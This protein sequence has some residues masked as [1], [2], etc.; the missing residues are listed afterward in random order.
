MADTPAHDKP[1]VESR[2][3]YDNLRAVPERLLLYHA[4]GTIRRR[5]GHDARKGRGG[6]GPCE[7]YVTEELAERL[8]VLAGRDGVFVFLCAAEE[9]EYLCWCSPDWLADLSGS[10]QPRERRLGSLVVVETHQ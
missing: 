1:V 6:L 5:R 10:G 9:S 4:F 8:L 2:I 3:E 7:E